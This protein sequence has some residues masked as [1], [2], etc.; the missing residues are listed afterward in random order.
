[1]QTQVLQ[2]HTEYERKQMI[3]LMPLRNV[4]V[5]LMTVDLGMHLHRLVC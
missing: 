2:C 3:C 5:L 4:V 1:M